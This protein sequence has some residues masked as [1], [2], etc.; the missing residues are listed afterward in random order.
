M[1]YVFI[2][3]YLFVHFM[4][5]PWL[6][7]RGRHKFILYLR[8]MSKPRYKPRYWKTHSHRSMSFI[9]STVEQWGRI[10]HDHETVTKCIAGE[11]ALSHVQWGTQDMRGSG[12][13]YIHTYNEDYIMIHF[14]FCQRNCK[15]IIRWKILW[16]EER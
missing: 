6:I 1:F 4:S 12:I 11:E 5:I 10:E 2:H 9:M 7:F 14:A 16:G 8:M 15:Q 3:V 13:L